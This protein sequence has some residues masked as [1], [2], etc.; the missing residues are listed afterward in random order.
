MGLFGDKFRAERER[1]GFT[2]DDVSN[3]TKICSRMLK[4]IEEENFDQLPGG[5]FNKGFI[6]S[7]A[8]HLGLN[9]EEAVNEYLSLMRE[10]QVDARNA[11]WEAAQSSG[12]TDKAAEF[13]RKQSQGDVP[14]N[15]VPVEF[16]RMKLGAK[17]AADTSEPEEPLAEIIFRQRGG[18][19]RAR[20]SGQSMPWKIAAMVAV[21]ILLV[22]VLRVRHS[23]S[24]RAEGESSGVAA[25]APAPV[26]NVAVTE[27]SGKPALIPAVSS[28]AI[29]NSPS[30]TAKLSSGIQESVERVPEPNAPEHKVLAVAAAAKPAVANALNQ[31]VVHIRASETSWISVTADGQ[32]VSQET[33]I[34]P[35]Q[36]VVRAS[37]EV[38]VK[39][40]NA[41]GVSF[42]M[43]GKEFPAQ[44]AEGEVKSYVFDS[45]GL[46]GN[47]Q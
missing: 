29:A 25:S 15:A 32:L 13:Y 10:K 42:E 9:D 3:V 40:G 19:V 18:N 16:R 41:A 5:I 36:T 4:A 44:G 22:F 45:T 31:F 1:R 34:A 47:A 28:K 11:A 35:A 17:A 23:R 37:H 46:R 12:K 43:N 2:L 33:L 6:R 7:Y 26:T 21:A 20:K 38:I 8:K 27:P 30:T 14:A 39:A 24:A